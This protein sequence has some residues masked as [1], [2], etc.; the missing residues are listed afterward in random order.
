MEGLSKGS[1]SGERWETTGSGQK[2]EGGG[3]TPPIKKTVREILTTRNRPRTET[4]YIHII[5]V[6]FCF[7]EKGSTYPPE[8]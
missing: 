7:R 4:L 1:T 5:P 3:K 2:V 6:F 8:S